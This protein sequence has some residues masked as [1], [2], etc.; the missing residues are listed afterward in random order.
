MNR[1]TRLSLQGWSAT[2]EEA[3][4]VVAAV[5]QFLRDAAPPAAPPAPEPSHWARAA[6]LEGVEREPRR[7]PW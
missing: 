2:P 5:E 3:A 6:R 7:D 1:R 4:A